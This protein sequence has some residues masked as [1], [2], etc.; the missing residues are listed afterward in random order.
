M[1]STNHLVTIEQAEFENELVEFQDLRKIADR[2][3]EFFNE[4]FLS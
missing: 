3:K 4:L 1:G 2:S